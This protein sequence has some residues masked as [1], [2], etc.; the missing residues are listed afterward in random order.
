M[1][2]PWPMTVETLTRELSMIMSSGIA[3]FSA[4]IA[5]KGE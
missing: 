2:E 3:P 4:V 5:S 1:H